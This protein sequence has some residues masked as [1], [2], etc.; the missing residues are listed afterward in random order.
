MYDTL[1]QVLEY[2]SSKKQFDA[3]VTTDG[4]AHTYRI[5]MP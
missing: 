1:C 2:V 5:A 4:R 3:A